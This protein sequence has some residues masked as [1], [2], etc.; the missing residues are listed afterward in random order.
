MAQLCNLELT[1]TVLTLGSGPV[2]RQQHLE[3][4]LK[5]NL[6][7]GRVIHTDRLEDGGGTSTR[8]R[9]DASPR[10]RIR[11]SCCSLA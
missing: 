5:L 8:R 9:R 6:V 2:D 4:Q 3:D 7:G 1:G 10:R 11:C